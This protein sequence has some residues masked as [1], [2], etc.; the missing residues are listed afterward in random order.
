MVLTDESIEISLPAE[1]K[2]SAELLGTSESSERAAVGADRG[3]MQI[4]HGGCS[5]G[6]YFDTI[7]LI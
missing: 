7:L 5:G 1:T 2:L 6:R 3:T 4:C